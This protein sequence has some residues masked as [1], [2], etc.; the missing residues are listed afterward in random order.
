[1]IEIRIHGRGG[2][3]AV[4]ASQILAE[5][6]FLQGLHVQAFPSFGSER[7]GAPVAAFVRL[8]EEPILVRTEIYEPDGLV[9]LDESLIT[10][11]LVDV[12]H[13][14]RPGGWILINSA[15]GPEAF[16]DLGEFR[17]ATVPASKIAV[18]HHLG[19]LTAPIVNTAICGAV[20]AFTGIVG[21][22]S[23]A[24]AIRRHVPIKPE[25]NVAAAMEAAKAVRELQPAG[26]R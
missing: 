18:E 11:G 7:R 1:M 4:I 25:E 14:L 3:G 13:G 12:T 5:A 9:V 15:H 20:A 19:S 2:Q 21:L 10:L 6:G 24:E 8:G 26:G 23:L 17:I 16:A 22:D